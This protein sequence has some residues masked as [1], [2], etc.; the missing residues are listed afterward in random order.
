MKRLKKLPST[1]LHPTLLALQRAVEQRILSAYK[2]QPESRRKPT[3]A[4]LELEL[5]DTPFL[6]RAG[7]D[8]PAVQQARR[9]EARKVPDNYFASYAASCACCDG[10]HKK[11]VGL[12][13]AD[14]MVSNLYS[15]FER[16]DVCDV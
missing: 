11:S 13:F 7:K 8:Q 12:D 1:P 14:G 6:W 10:E 16:K 2:P 4:E 5:E 9:N 3:E 15:S